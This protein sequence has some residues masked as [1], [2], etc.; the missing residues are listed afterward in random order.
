M[1]RQYYSW[2]RVRGC[3]TGL[4]TSSSKE[5]MLHETCWSHG[6]PGSRAFFLVTVLS[7]PYLSIISN[8]FHS[9][10]DVD[11]DLLICLLSSC[12]DDAFRRTIDLFE[13]VV[14][15]NGP[16]SRSTYYGFSHASW[17]GSRN[18]CVH[19]AQKMNPTDFRGPFLFCHHEVEMFLWDGKTTMGLSWN[20]VYTFVFP[21][22]LFD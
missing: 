22:G 11:I 8:G 13:I 1:G 3:Q 21:T 2:Q 7:L 20:L 4:P 10:I 6:G 18:D 19:G 12:H 16:T 17:S 15:L 9:L 14:W 5:V